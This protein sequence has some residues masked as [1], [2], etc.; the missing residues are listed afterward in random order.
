MR[1][2]ETQIW[3]LKQGERHIGLLERAAAWVRRAL[4]GGVAIIAVLFLAFLVLECWTATP[5]NDSS[6]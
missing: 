2:G 3:T 5:S 1:C 4:I 6:G